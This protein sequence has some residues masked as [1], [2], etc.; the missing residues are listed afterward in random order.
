MGILRIGRRLGKL[1]WPALC[2][3]QCPIR[4]LGADAGHLVRGGS[5]RRGTKLMRASSDSVRTMG[6]S[7]GQAVM[8]EKQN[9]C[10]HRRW[11][12]LRLAGAREVSTAIVL[13]VPLP[14]IAEC[15]G[16]LEM[17]AGGCRGLP[18]NWGW[19]YGGIT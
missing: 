12:V 9:S 7:S 14:L 5:V 1:I 15:K 11:S 3:R 17:E 6:G 4:G 8:P 13:G 16:Y 19:R 10:Q 2:R 18:P